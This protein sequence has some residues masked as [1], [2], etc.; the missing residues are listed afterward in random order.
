V[1]ERRDLRHIG[2]PYAL[3]FGLSWLAERSRP[4]AVI[5]VDADCEVHDGFVGAMASR[6]A[7]GADAVQGH[8]MASEG[9]SSLQRLRRLAF[10]LLNWSR[11]LG[12]SRLGASV[13]IKGSGMAIRWHVL[14]GR[15]GAYGVAEDAELTLRLCRQNVRVEFEPAAQVEGTMAGSFRAARTQDRRWEGG[16]LRLAPSAIKTAVRAVTRGRPGVAVAAL[17]VA[18]LPYSLVLFA[19]AAGLGLAALGVGSLWLAVGSTASLATYAIFGL[20]AARPSPR[21]IASLA[22]VPR[23]LWHKAT[24]FADLAVRGVPTAWER[25]D[26][27]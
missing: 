13:T 25:T 19:A 20:A 5:F 3:D 23:F 9:G 16:R 15:L 14:K 1:I 12:A 2:K 4:D 26:R 17:E 11:P 8:Y 27:R 22:L 6:L 21:E 18:A 7:A 10:Y 24:V